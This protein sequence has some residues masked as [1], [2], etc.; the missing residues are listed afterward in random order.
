MA[1]KRWRNARFGSDLRKLHVQ[2]VFN[3]PTAIRMVFVEKFGVELHTKER[4]LSVLHC[5]D[6]AAFIGRSSL[7]TWWNFLHFVK[8]GV[9]NS[10]LM[11]QALEE[12]VSCGVTFDFNSEETAFASCAFIAFARFEPSHQFY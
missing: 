4:T 1:L 8:V 2:K 6:G 9:P 7:K 10:D 12:A 5:L 11:R 3:N